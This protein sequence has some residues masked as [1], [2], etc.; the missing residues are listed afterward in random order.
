M[1]LSYY[2]LALTHLPLEKNGYHLPNNIFKYIFMN[3]KF[4]VLIQISLTFVPNGLIDNNPALV[5][6]KGWRQ[7]DKKP[8]SEPMLTWSSDAYMQHKGRGVKPSLWY[9][10]AHKI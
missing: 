9:Q 5:K 3:L 4:C 2:S 6:I 1:H 10:V 8:L 7:I